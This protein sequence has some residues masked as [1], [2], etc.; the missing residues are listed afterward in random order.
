MSTST[1]IGARRP[2]TASTSPMSN[3][4]SRAPIGGETIGQTVEGLAR[5]PI[6]VRYP[7][8]LRDSLEATAHPADADAVGSADHAWHRR[9][10]PIADGPPMLKTEN[11]G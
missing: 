1:S 10:C 6:S 9:Q 7:R 3:R 5:Y 8:E 2:A 11:G 4:S